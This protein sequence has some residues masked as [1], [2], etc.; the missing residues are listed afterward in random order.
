MLCNRCGSSLR[1][2][3]PHVLGTRDGFG[4]RKSFYDPQ[5]NQ[6]IDTWKKWAKAGFKNIGDVKDH[7]NP[8]VH[9]KAKWFAK[10]KN[11]NKTPQLDR[12]MAI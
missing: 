5:T 2:S 3:V 11:T 7:R 12:A 1:G 8:E 9:D 4:I 6:T 10:R